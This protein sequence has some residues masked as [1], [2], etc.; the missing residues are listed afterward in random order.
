[1]GEQ[2][3]LSYGALP[4]SKLLTFYGFAC[5]GNPYNELSLTLTESLVGSHGWPAAKTV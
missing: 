5:K 2:L 3:L 4:N 1:M